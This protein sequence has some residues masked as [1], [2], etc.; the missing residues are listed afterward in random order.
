MKLI[1]CP[2]CATVFN[3]AQKPKTCACQ[4]CGGQ[5]QPD[6]INAEYYGPAVLFGLG[7]TSFLR[8]IAIQEVLDHEGHS[9]AGATFDAFIIPAR[10]ATISKATPMTNE[11]EQDLKAYDK[12]MEEHLK[13]PVVY[14]HA[15]VCKILDKE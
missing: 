8:A 11:D 14:S 3:L 15:D 6:G 4:K 10:A 5:Y 1:F 13:N 7:N 2:E 9:A 12:A